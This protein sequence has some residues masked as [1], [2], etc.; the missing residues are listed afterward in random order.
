[1][2]LNEIKTQLS[3]TDGLPPEARYFVGREEQL[4]HIE[5]KCNQHGAVWIY[6]PGRCGKTTLALR[7][8]EQRQTHNTR[9][10]HID[11]SDI[12]HGNVTETLT[13]VTYALQGKSHPGNAD[14]KNPTAFDPTGTDA[15]AFTEQLK[16][17]SKTGWVGII[18]DEFDGVAPNM[19]EDAQNFLRTR[20]QQCHGR[21]TFIFVT[22]AAPREIIANES[23][24]EASR[25]LEVSLIQQ[26]PIFA[27]SDVDDLFTRIAKDAGRDDLKDA[28][29]HVWRCVGGHCVS[30]IK[31]ACRIL[32]RCIEE[33]DNKPLEK[34]IKIA[35]NSA[36][37]EVE[38]DL[39]TLWKHL[40][41]A[42]RNY[43]LSDDDSVLDLD[44]PNTSTLQNLGFWDPY[45]GACRPTWLREVGQMKGQTSNAPDQEVSQ[46]WDTLSQLIKEICEVAHSQG[47]NAPFLPTR[48]LMYRG[49]LVKEMT[50]EHDF[51]EAIDFLYMV[52]H[53]SALD[54]AK[55]HHSSWRMSD[56]LSAPYSQSLGHQQV[57]WLRNSQRHLWETLTE[58]DQKE[59]AESVAKVFQSYCQKTRAKTLHDFNKVRRGVTNELVTA[60]RQLL[61]AFE[62][63]ATN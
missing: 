28:A 2:N 13:R 24:T 34:K 27:E 32:Q 39:A 37:P 22:R 53:D 58:K 33:P 62:Q 18:F 48:L 38:S 56:E 51:W 10:V 21:L 11:C 4:Q 20:L 44:E 14:R 15:R 7:A 35:C 23:V 40:P 57:K 54:K 26:L 31:L 12:H 41:A 25:L 61:K 8:C 30:V 16:T 59:A 3:H 46:A 17:H 9:T 60:M 55:I 5:D 42:V 52:A 6:G 63:R 29:S 50:D 19:N 45:R 47:Q 49:P 36:K 43:L 1:M